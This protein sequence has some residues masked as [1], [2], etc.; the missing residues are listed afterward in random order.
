MI[1]N[2]IESLCDSAQAFVKQ[3][4]DLCSDRGLKV[5]L[6]ETYRSP[7][8]QLDLFNKG[9]SK[10]KRGGM[11]EY[12]I[13][14]DIVFVKEG[15]P[16]WDKNHKWK[17]LGQTG[18]DLGL[19]GLCWGGNWTSFTDLPHFQVVPATPNDQSLIR[20]GYTPPGPF[21]ILKYKDRGYQVKLLQSLLTSIKVDGMY[22]NQ[23]KERVKFHQSLS[24]YLTV[25]GVARNG[26][27]KYL[28]R[29]VQ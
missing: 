21:P 13:A 27:W 6:F 26:L 15:K 3:Q 1:T 20:G 8:R 22:G 2:S 7:E 9:Y 16:S 4:L 29:K 5:R 11:H 25:D 14:W 12:R 19:D 23:T 28:I 24:G 17:A 18:A 10:L